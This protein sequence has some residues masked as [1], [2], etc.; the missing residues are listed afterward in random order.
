MTMRYDHRHHATLDADGP[1]TINGIRLAEYGLFTTRDGV[2]VGEA[3]PTLTYTDV[4]G[5]S[6]GIDQTTTDA[7]GAAYTGRRDVTINVAT[8]GDPIEISEAKQ[9]IGALAG[10]IVS[11]GGIGPHGEYRGRMTV[12]AW[13][14]TPA[15]GRTATSATTLT[16]NA[17]PYCYG[18]PVT[19]PVNA[20][21]NRLLIQGNAMTPPQWTLT[22]PPG[23][24]TTD[25]TVTDQTDM[26][27]TIVCRVTRPTTAMSLTLDAETR[28][29]RLN[30]TLQAIR[31]DSDWW[32]LRP[33]INTITSSHAGRLSYT[34]RWLT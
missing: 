5:M 20:G 4:P 10:R 15:A 14:D 9:R 27:R 32:P 8:V 26:G 24:G 19:L 3:K 2:S 11:V 12:G 16:V 29:A 25:A 18:R 21:R 30:G 7:T 13:T 1:V 22:I 33:G 34:P 6:G 17:D 23:T 28:Q 31:L